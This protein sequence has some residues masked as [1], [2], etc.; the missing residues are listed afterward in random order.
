MT[1]DHRLE[2]RDCRTDD[3][4]ALKAMTRRWFAGDD[5]LDA[6]WPGMEVLLRGGV[7][8]GYADCKENIIDG[9]LVDFDL[10]GRGY[11]SYLLKH[12][13]QRLFERHDELFLE[14]FEESAQANG[15]Y[16]KNGW[17]EVRRYL[18][19]GN[20]GMRKVLYCKAKVP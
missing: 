5:Y 17:R 15:F 9:M 10:H 20:T 19:E 8:I 13:E 18:D 1:N 12:C 14:C 16:R 2:I 6:H 3:L 11:G 4:D 7:P